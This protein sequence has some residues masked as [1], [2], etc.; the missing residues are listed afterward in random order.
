MT[1]PGLQKE[2]LQLRS[3]VEELGFLNELSQ[4]IGS[5]FKS[6]EIM[7]IIIRKS[8]RAIHAE[9]GTVILV[10]N[11]EDLEM[12]TYVRSMVSYGDRKPFSL[13][14]SI[15][16][17]MHIHLKPVSIHDPKNDDRF[18]GVEW[19]ESVLSIAC[20]PLIVKSKLTGVLSLYNKKDNK[21][22]TD[23]DLRLMSIIAAQS[24]QIVENARLYE[25]EQALLKL[26]EESRVAKNIQIN[27]L[28]K[29]NPVIPGYDIAG[30]SIPAQSVGG[31]Y[32]DFIPVG[33]DKIAAC[34]GDISGKGMPAAML[35]ANLQATIR[36]QSMIE[37]PVNDCVH[38]SNKLLY[39]STEMNRYAT[40]FYGIVNTKT[41]EFNYTNAG[42]NPP[43]LYRENSKPAL[44]KSGGPV[45]GFIDNAEYSEETIKLKK[46]DMIV[47]YS[48][49]ISEAMDIEEQE[50][51]EERLDK[52][53]SEIRSLSSNE[54]IEKT[55]QSVMDYAG[56][57]PQFD[58]M[59]M[60][61]IK[62]T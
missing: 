5:S 38:R 60:V 23:E 21:A 34:L 12:K 24:A 11:D 32:Y 52:L 49:G 15:L 59:T 45:L 48:D 56:E 61:V 8:I 40:F 4:A 43:I 35:M 13:N 39:M 16:G 55:F 58:D 27:L 1:E 47:I 26:K 62:R 18:V 9:Q 25:E 37:G 36:G 20:V 51:S 19:D 31:D 53:L 41:H 42:H 33:E 10:D 14:Q 6:E 54:I 57:A 3:A 17:W 22:F 29:T 50:Y 46:G 2:N 30:K 28:P 7:Q 44:L